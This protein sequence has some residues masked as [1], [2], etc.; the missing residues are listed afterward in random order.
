VAWP[1]PSAYPRE[2]SVLYIMGQDRSGST[3]LGNVLGSMEG[4]AHVGEVRHLWADGFLRGGRCGCG[5]PV[6]ECGLWA[7][8][9]DEALAG[10]DATP[11]T[12]A[13]WGREIV[14]L[15]R[16]PRIL[17][18]TSGR[19]GWEAFDAY[20]AVTARLYRALARRTGAAVLV[21]SSKH[22]VHAALVSRLPGVEARFVHLVRDPRAVAH[23]WGRRKDDPQWGRDGTMWRRPAGAAARAWV[24]ANLAAVRVRRAVGPGRS[25][26]LRYE[27]VTSH[28]AGALR[29]LAG[30]AGRP[31]ASPPISTEHVAEIRGGHGVSGNPAKF[32]TGPV[33][34]RE[35]DEWL[36]GQTS[37]DRFV[38]TALTLP[39]LSRYGY[40]TRPARQG[41]R[42][43]ERGR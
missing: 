10:T 11:A 22:P 40:R 20:G 25:V 37:R 7:D 15:R 33:E 35:D 16:L 13:A 3:V 23:S 26:L 34:I 8:V 14:R 1:A 17:R 43:G 6:P 30:L 5:R 12:V 2:A 24:L 36:A 18:S 28:P 21:D 39:W 9:A 41:Y 4:F 19:S 42:A 38:V 32:R 31:G 29:A 27:D